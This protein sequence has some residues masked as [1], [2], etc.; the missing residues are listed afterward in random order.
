MRKPV[1]HVVLYVIFLSLLVL[2]NLLAA[3]H[4]IFH[5]RAPTVVVTFN[6]QILRQTTKPAAVTPN[7]P[8][9]PPDCLSA[10]TTYRVT[11]T[12]TIRASGSTGNYCGVI[13]KSALVGF[14]FDLFCGGI[15]SYN[16]TPI[17]LGTPWYT[18]TS[19]SYIGNF[20]GICEIC[21]DGEPVLWPE[22]SITLSAEPIGY[23][24]SGKQYYVDG[25]PST[26][27]AM[28]NSP[29]YTVPCP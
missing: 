11:G 5:I 23:D 19:R 7:P 13:M 15:S 8:I 4:G 9:N 16:Y 6:G 26:T 28:R 10:N 2:P 12:N 1:T 29:N 18:G 24:A 3:A 20:T 22:F 27:Q 14:S 17:L 21:T 25:A